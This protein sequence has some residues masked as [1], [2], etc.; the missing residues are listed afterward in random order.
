MNDIK[1][2]TAVVMTSLLKKH[3]SNSFDNLLTPWSFS[4]YMYRCKRL[5]WDDNVN[6]EYVGMTDFA[7]RLALEEGEE[8]EHDTTRK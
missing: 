7:Q 1:Q 8:Q 6:L 5:L 2:T 4:A 3:K